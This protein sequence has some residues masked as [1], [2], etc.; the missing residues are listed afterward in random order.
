MRE[1]SEVRAGQDRT[2]ANTQTLPVGFDRSAAPIP[3]YVNQNAIALRLTRKTCAGSAKRYSLAILP[4]IAEHLAHVVD[5]MGDHDY[6][7]EQP[8]GAGISGEADN[9]DGPTENAL[10]AEERDEIIP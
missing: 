6:L 7:R 9:I 4:R 3:S 5:V 10:G 8:I 2:R 1:E